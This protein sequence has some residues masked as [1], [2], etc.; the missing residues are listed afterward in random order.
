MPLQFLGHGKETQT[1]L[2]YVKAIDVMIVNW[3]WTVVPCIWH[4]LS[5]LNP[6]NS[7]E[8]S[9]LLMSKKFTVIHSQVRI[10]IW[11][12]SLVIGGLL[13][14]MLLN[15][16]IC[17]SNSRIRDPFVIASIEGFIMDVIFVWFISLFLSGLII[18]N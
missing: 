6:R 15:F 9:I 8:L 13:L 1:K 3:V 10:I 18:Y 16:L 5:E 12:D 2:T 17:L 7:F 11:M 14:R 4:V